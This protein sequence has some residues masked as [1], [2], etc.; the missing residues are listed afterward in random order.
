MKF[1]G[2]RIRI[3][4]VSIY[5]FLYILFVVLGNNFFGASVFQLLD[6]LPDS[7]ILLGIYTYFYISYFQSIVS[8]NNKLVTLH[9]SVVKLIYINTGQ[10]IRSQFLVKTL[11]GFDGDLPFTLETG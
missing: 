10:T 7:L 1:Y 8:T 5:N 11:P 9:S 6:S 2:F 3:T 4:P